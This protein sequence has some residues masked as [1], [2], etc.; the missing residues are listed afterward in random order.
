MIARLRPLALVAVVVLL[1]GCSG[2]APSSSGVTPPSS[3]GSPSGSSETQTVVQS[4]TAS[5]VAGTSGGFGFTQTQ[6]QCVA[7]GFVKV[8]GVQGLVTMGVLDSSLAPATSGPIPAMDA[9]QAAQAADVT[10]GCVDG[11]QFIQQLMANG[12][13]PQ[14]LVDCVVNNLGDQTVRDVLIATFQDDQTKLQAALMPVMGN[15]TVG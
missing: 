9:T 6:A 3:A 2:S 4:L 14:T 8:F 13:A 12:A 11:K 7:E 5:L 1:A 10:L 15:C